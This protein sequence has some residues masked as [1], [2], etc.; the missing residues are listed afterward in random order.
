[1]PFLF[2]KK[3][4]SYEKDL[5]ILN[6]R[7]IFWST[8]TLPHE[9]FPETSLQKYPPLVR[10][11]RSSAMLATVAAPVVAAPAGGCRL[12]RSNSPLAAAVAVAAAIVAVVVAF[13]LRRRRCLCRRSVWRRK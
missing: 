8:A 11:R 7:N 13:L 4:I 5:K 1:M 9:N 6:F 10:L 12:R 2:E 3:L